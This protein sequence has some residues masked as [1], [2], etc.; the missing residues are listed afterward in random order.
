MENVYTICGMCTVRCPIM[1][2]VENGRIVSLQGN[3][4]VPA[5]AGGLCPRGSAGRAL[6]EDSERPQ[7]PLIRQGERGEGRWR[8]VS[9]DEAFD[10][11][12]D[13][14]KVVIAEHGARTVAMTDRGGPFRDMHRALLRGLGSPNYCNHDG[15]CARN[16]QH[17]NLSVTGL[18]R[19]GV[20]YDY[21]HA[22]HVVL[23][24]RNIFE[25]VD[26]QEVNTL[27][28]A[29]EKGCR[30]SVIDIRAN[31]SSTKAH[32]FF[33]LRPGT[34]YAFNLA[35]IHVL[36][37]ERLYD[38]AYADRY[39]QGVDDLTQFIEPYTPE[40][41]ETETGIAADHLRQFV[42]RLAD[43]AP[44]VI[45]H[46][47]WMTARYRHSF[48]VCRS[49]YMINA[50]LGA[51]G[52]KGGLPLVNKPGDVGR[53]GLKKF[54]DL[55]PA[56]EE[57]RADGVGWRYTH[58]DK[59]PGMAHLMFKAM[60]TDN[61]YPVKAYIAYRHD[62]LMGF[63]DPDHLKRILDRLDLLVAVTFSW[64][65]T[66]W[67]ADVVLPLSTYLERECVLAC[68]NAL[69][70]Y[71]FARQRAVEPCYDTLADWK[72]VG[73]LARR[74]G[75]PQLDC[76]SIEDIW[77]FQL[78]ETGVSPDAFA[79]TGMVYL[80]DGPVY[81]DRD[82]LSFKTPSGKIE[83]VSG[84]LE[85]HGITSLMPYEALERPP[86]GE[87]RL[88]FG[89]CATHTQGHTVNNPLLFEQMPENVLWI[90]TTAA[91]GMGIED[92]DRVAVSQNG[93]SETIT[94]KVTDM[95]HPEAV[96]VIH[97]FGHTCPAESRA[98]G[99]GL[100]DNKFMQGGLDLWDPAGGAV[101]FQEHFVS[102]R[103]VNES[104][105]EDGAANQTAA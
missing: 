104:S 87:F 71:F 102:I 24:T 4:H 51:F 103:K 91:A 105:T 11:V 23:Q 8:Q 85:S 33:M 46:P 93:Y 31:V 88:T 9:W 81:R 25:A 65:D 75:L 52:T 21:A 14:L 74:L 38:V 83:M 6:V 12:A 96:F 76:K 64:S 29:M 44:A 22:R 10:F 63:P 50:L 69:R 97:G 68:K 67:F 84:H 5:M 17:A 62:P 72:I 82:Q 35:V 16:V 53:N 27:M 92:G 54:M 61:P 32:D 100:A 86:Q 45:W 78:E 37:K 39:I 42:R 66:A 59:G 36:I 95:I 101:A 55:F 56:P 2:R 19:K 89:R 79:A 77:R 73:G 40:W 90:N 49:I 18:G 57:K 30:L 20:V 43:A 80:S 28:A 13:R 3:P 70:P 58:F 48:Y 60:E 98:R 99:K 41:A 7:A 15:S 26:V 47:G 1:A 94:A 34:D